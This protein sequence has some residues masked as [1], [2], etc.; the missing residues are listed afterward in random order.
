VTLGDRR[1][2]ARRGSLQEHGVTAVRVR[3]G[4]RAHLID[5]SAEGAQL[6]TTERLPPG[7]VVHVQLTWRSGH[8]TL[9]ARVLR[10]DVLQLNADRIRYR[11]GVRFDRALRWV[12]EH[13]QWHLTSDEVSASL[14]GS[15]SKAMR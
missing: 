12:A 4:I 10:N 8:L 15:D 14:A 9:R 3:P 7:R 11:C 5:V 1:A 13:G 6:V 2:A